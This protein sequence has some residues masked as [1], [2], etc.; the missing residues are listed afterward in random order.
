[1]KRPDQ[2]RLLRGILADDNVEALRAASL[3][4]G[5]TLLRARRRRRASVAMVASLAAIAAALLTP[6]SD[7]RLPNE[8][9]ALSAPAATPTKIITDEQLLAL[10]PEQS[11]ALVGAPGTQRL[12]L[13]APDKPSRQRPTR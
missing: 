12:I 1:M 11:V 13:S 8:R 2:E 10:F 3:A 6:R 4:R 9:E 5:L 7:D